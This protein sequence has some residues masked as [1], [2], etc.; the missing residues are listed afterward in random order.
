VTQGQAAASRIGE[1]LGTGAPAP[2]AEVGA[3]A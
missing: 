1:W 2:R 3:R